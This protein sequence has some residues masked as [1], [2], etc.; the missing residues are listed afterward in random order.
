M[1]LSLKNYKWVNK[2]LR[3]SC[4]SRFCTYRF[5]NDI[6]AYLFWSTGFYFER[7]SLIQGFLKGGGVS[8][9]NFNFQRGVPPSKCV[10]FTFFWQDFFYEGGGGVRQRATFHEALY[11]IWREASQSMPS[12]TTQIWNKVWVSSCY[13]GYPGCTVSNRD[14]Y[15]IPF[16]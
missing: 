9:I 7:I 6:D 10:M 12:C 3:L 14:S 16:M 1:V 15:P 11:N 13:K 4:E 2:C 8:T 5:R